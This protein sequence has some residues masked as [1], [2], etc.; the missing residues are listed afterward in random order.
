[1]RLTCLL[2]LLVTPIWADTA[3]APEVEIPGTPK[4]KVPACSSCDAR[5]AGL[6][7]LKSARDAAQVTPKSVPGDE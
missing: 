1:M 4:L 5:K 7:A 3:P 2:I 6:K